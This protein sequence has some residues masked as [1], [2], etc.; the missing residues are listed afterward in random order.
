MYVICFWNHQQYYGSFFFLMCYIVLWPKESI[1][2]TNIF[3]RFSS[4]NAFLC[5]PIIIF[6]LTSR[7]LWL[8]VVEVPKEDYTVVVACTVAAIVAVLLALCIWCHRKRRRRRRGLHRPFQ[9][10]VPAGSSRRPPQHVCEEL[11]ERFASV[12]SVW[13]WLL[14]GCYSYYPSPAIRYHYRVARNLNVFSIIM[15][16]RNTKA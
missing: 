16:R 3:L 4:W 5:S 15:I 11:G 14:L 10:P 13:C 6:S 2:L 8:G 1:W 12:D 9:L 7:T